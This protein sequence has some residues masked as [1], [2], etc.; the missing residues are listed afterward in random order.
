MAN[1]ERLPFPNGRFD[2]A[3]CVGSVINFCDAA[4][5]VL[6]LC[7]IVAPGG[8][9]L[10]EFEVSESAEYLFQVAHRADAAPVHTFEEDRT[11]RL[12]VY[13]EAYI[14]AILSSAGMQLVKRRPIHVLSPYVYWCTR[15]VA[16]SGWLASRLDAPLRR[17]AGLEGGHGNVIYLCRKT[18]SMPAG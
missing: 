1:G 17:F 2:A 5:V 10:L 12:W 18:L 6:E 13:S 11:T 16:L 8:H 4:L 9:V 15:S 3:I 7:R 14:R